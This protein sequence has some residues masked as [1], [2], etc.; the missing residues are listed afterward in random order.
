MTHLR[1]ESFW[2]NPRFTLDAAYVYPNT[3]S[4]KIGA[5]R[6]REQ[7]SYGTLL[8]LQTLGDVVDS[9]THDRRTRDNWRAWITHLYSQHNKKQPNQAFVNREAARLTQ[10]TSQVPQQLIDEMR[11][12][13]L[14][15]YEPKEHELVALVQPNDQDCDEE[16]AY[17]VHRGGQCH[18][19]RLDAY[20]ITHRTGQT[21][22]LDARR[23]SCQSRSGTLGAETEYAGQR[24]RSFLA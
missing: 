11:R 1:A 7:L 6:R 3:S 24:K 2:H 19:V 13:A 16:P 21:L 20:Y 15:D 23:K 22:S 5:R 14:L 8:D 12:Q 4:A 18:E 10:L 17:A 9:T